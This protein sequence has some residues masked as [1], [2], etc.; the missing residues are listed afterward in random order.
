MDFV[1]KNHK[2][3][4]HWI[5]KINIITCLFNVIS[6]CLVMKKIERQKLSQIISAARGGFKMDVLI[7]YVSEHPMSF[8]YQ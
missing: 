5:V 7:S 8:I 1:K 6:T 4:I 3:L 2:I